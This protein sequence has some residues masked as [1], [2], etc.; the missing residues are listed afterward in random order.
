M[1]NTTDVW[2][3]VQPEIAAF[4]TVCSYDRMEVGQSDHFGRKQTE[5][6]IVRDLHQ[7]LTNAGVMPPYILVGHSM[8]GIYARKFAE[9]YPGTVSGFVF[10]DSA[11]EEQV[12]R[13]AKIAPMLLF[14]Y[15]E[16]P[17][18]GKLQA[19]GWLL[20]GQ[21]LKWKTD[22]PVI[23]LEHGKTWPRGMFK[24][25]S[26]EQYQNVKDTWHAMQL[27]L[28]TRSPYSELKTVADSGHNIHREQPGMV[29]DAIH[30]VLNKVPQ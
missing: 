28:S 17:Y 2:K 13:Y 21:V 23:V 10:V 30:D 29:V 25:M 27:D 26:E 19:Q 16:W 8:G 11:H 18:Y 22:A 24:G 7:L 15:P 3:K 9:V 4:A 14:E 20:P 1:D 5:D 6:E 12:W